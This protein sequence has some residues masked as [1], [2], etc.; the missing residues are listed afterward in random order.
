M[1]KLFHMHKKI[2]P[3]HEGE[4]GLDSSALRGFRSGDARLERLGRSFPSLCV[5]VCEFS[6]LDILM[7]QIILKV[8]QILLWFLTV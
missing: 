6:V 1:S 8:T 4:F 5:L 2:S 3:G 7:R